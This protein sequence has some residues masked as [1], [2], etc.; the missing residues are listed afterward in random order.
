MK[1]EKTMSLKKILV[2]ILKGFVAM[3]FATTL[4]L[5]S[6][7]VAVLVVNNLDPKVVKALLAALRVVATL[8]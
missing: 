6:T 5:I 3:L 7:G 2:E 1:T 4:A 8:L